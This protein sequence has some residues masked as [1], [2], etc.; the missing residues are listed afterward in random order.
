MGGL[1]IQK[2]GG[3]EIHAQRFIYQDFFPLV[4]KAK[5]I[6][7]KNPIT[8]TPFCHVRYLPEGMEGM[9]APSAPGGPS[10][11]PRATGFKGTLSLLCDDD[12]VS[13][14]FRGRRKPATS[15]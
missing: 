13:G 8:D 14:F 1:S 3:P 2:K 11:I 10:V 12:V 5:A 9:K 6:R 4:P 15:F 7:C